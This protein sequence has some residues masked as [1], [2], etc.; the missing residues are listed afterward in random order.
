MANF[1]PV[2]A[3]IGGRLIGLSAVLSMPFT[4]RIAGV[5]GILGDFIADGTAASMSTITA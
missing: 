5:S 2:S 3:A 1:T 4:G